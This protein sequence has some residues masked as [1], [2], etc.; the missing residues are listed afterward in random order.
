[1]ADVDTRRILLRRVRI[2]GDDDE[3]GPEVDVLIDNG[4][5]A[6]VSEAPI[7]Q[8]HCKTIYVPGGILTPG[9][10]DAHVHFTDWVQS[11][12]FASVEGLSD[13]AS[14]LTRLREHATAW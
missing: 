4:V 3:L 5:V 14:I 13:E 10:C 8:D 7:S 9:L 11:E 6:E 12:S 1:M 2:F